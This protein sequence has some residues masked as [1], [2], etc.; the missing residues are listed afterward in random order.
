MFPVLFPHGL[1]G[2]QESALIVQATLLMLI[3]IV[4]VLGLLFFFAWKYRAT[5]TKAR[6]EPNWEH[7]ALDE[8]VWWAVPIEIVLVL[9][10]VTWVS[11]H[12]LDPRTPLPS[13]QPTL[14]IE[15]V[16][17]PW[18]WLFIYPT[19]GIA[20]VNELILPAGTPVKFDITADAP[21]NSFFI[22]AL[23]GQIYAMTG[24][25]NPLYLRADEPGTY[26][27]MSANYSGSGFADMRF[28][29]RAVTQ[30]SFSAWAASAHQASTTLT[31][32]AYTALAQPGTTT[33]LVYG[34]VDSGLFDAILSKYAQPETGH[35]H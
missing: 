25:V 35:H 8:L 13:D 1:I 9:A 16:A 33:T 20:T 6:Y 26:Q 12:K 32:T 5:N 2:A 14:S 19:L 30:D 10:A 21:M 4:P 23:G 18:K 28:E 3:V 31:K 11:T 24:M 34:A 7:S 22:P 27:G 15:V 17:L 29:A